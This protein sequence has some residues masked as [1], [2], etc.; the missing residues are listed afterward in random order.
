MQRHDGQVRRVRQVQRSP[1]RAHRPEGLLRHQGAPLRSLPECARAEPDAGASADA[2]EALRTTDE[3]SGMTT[4]A[5]TTP[6]QEWTRELFEVIDF[7]SGS[8][9]REELLAF[10]DIAVL[11]LQRTAAKA[12]ESK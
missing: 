12:K 5:R 1:V 10:C 4:Q 3:G 8:L 11:R 6:L 2:A 7:A 9:T